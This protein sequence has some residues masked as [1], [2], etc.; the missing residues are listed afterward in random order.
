MKCLK[1]RLVA[2]SLGGQ[3]PRWPV[4]LV[5]PGRSQRAG[6]LHLWRSSVLAL[7]YRELRRSSYQSRVSEIVREPQQFV[8]RL[9]LVR[10]SM[11]GRVLVVFWCSFRKAAVEMSIF[12]L[13][14]R[15]RL[16]VFRKSGRFTSTARKL[17]TIVER[18]FPHTQATF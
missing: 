4:G 10:L 11:A 8:S 3:R 2:F 17:L 12:T 1:L 7:F 6:W 16:T 18:L 9:S 15:L 13:L 14:S 5:L